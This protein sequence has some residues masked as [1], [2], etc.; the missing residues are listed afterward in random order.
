MPEAF[1]II[2]RFADAKIQGRHQ[3]M[4]AAASV[5]DQHQ[6]VA[7]AHAGAEVVV[8]PAY[9][10]SIACQAQAMKLPLLAGAATPTEVLSLV[11]QGADL[12]KFFPAAA[13]G[14][15][16]T[17]QAYHSLFPSVKFV[18][19]GGLNPD[20]LSQYCLPNVTAIA[21]SWL[22]TEADLAHQ[23]WQGIIRKCQTTFAMLHQ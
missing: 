22:I 20:N 23:D 1:A 3:M 19:T 4:L 11:A 17:L 7:G 6:V 10:A 5:V 2:E 21:G 16:A 12:I 8:S 13:L 14:G 15:G 9:S 18:A